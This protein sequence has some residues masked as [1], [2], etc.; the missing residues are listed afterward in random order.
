MWGH[1]LLFAV[2]AEALLGTHREGSS[3]IATSSGH[4]RGGI[5]DGGGRAGGIPDGW[6]LGAGRGHAIELGGG[7]GSR[8]FEGMLRL[9][10]GDPLDAEST[11]SS[12]EKDSAE[13]D[14]L[15]RS[16]AKDLGMKSEHGIKRIVSSRPLGRAE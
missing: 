13:M 16:K 14:E 9:R 3:M 15:A 8:R 12:E 2:V 10:G 5:L 11:H 4:V 1:A 6:L 7:Q